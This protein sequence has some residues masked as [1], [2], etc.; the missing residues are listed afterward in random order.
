MLL[1]EGF[2]ITNHIAPPYCPPTDP[3]EIIYDDPQILVINKPSGLLSVPGRGPEK[4]DCAISRVKNIHADVLTVHRLDMDTSGLLIFARGKD[5]QRALSMQFEKGQVTKRYIANV[6]GEPDEP[7]GL[8]DL[9]ILIDWPNRPRQKIDHETGKPSQTK[10]AIDGNHPHGAR[11]ILSPLTGRTHQLRIH[12]AAIR[13]P[14]LGDD[15]YA[16]EEALAVSPRLCLHADQL[17]FKHP[18]TQEI[19]NLTAPCPF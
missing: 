5:V 8:I 16:S 9:P 11:L 19:L 17:S 10:Y 6:W 7:S 13:N 12:L 14:I 18:L 4:A 15:L 1:A 3:L 2:L